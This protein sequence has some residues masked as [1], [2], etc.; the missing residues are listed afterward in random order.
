MHFPWSSLF[1]LLVLLGILAFYLRAP[2]KAFVRTRHESLRDEVARVGTQLK[3]AQHRYDEFS[4]KL[5]AI[6]AEVQAI[7]DQMRA[8]AD[9]VRVRVVNEARA[10]AQNIVADSRATSEAMFVEL[11]AQLRGELAQQVIDRAEGLIRERLTGDDRAR[12][13]SEFSQQLGGG[14]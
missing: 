1:N 11:K 12:I 10:L 3:D 6:E 9:A 7:H 5:K 13:R 2:L 4:A 14:R 8:D